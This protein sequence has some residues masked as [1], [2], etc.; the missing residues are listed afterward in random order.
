M[1]MHVE[2]IL[3]YC[4]LVDSV[5]FLRQTHACVNCVCFDMFGVSVVAE[6]SLFPLSGCC[7]FRKR[8]EWVYGML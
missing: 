7:M 8:M 5:L 1:L 3:K 6:S 2:D 4:V